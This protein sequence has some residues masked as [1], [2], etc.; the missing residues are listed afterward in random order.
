MITGLPITQTSCKS[1]GLRSHRNWLHPFQPYFLFP[2]YFAGKESATHTYLE[3]RVCQLSVT[4]ANPSILDLFDFLEASLLKGGV[5]IS[6]HVHEL[7]FSLSYQLYGL[8]NPTHMYFSNH[9][10]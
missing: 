8:T 3:P 6:A 2:L 10:L 4:E 7:L 1:Q 5:H 9:I